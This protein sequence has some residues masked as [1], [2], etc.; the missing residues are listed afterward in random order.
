V[1]V[2]YGGGLRSL[3]DIGAALDAGAS[4]V[5]LGTALFDEDV[6]RGALAAFGDRVAAALDAR[7]GAAAVEGW[8]RTAPLSV[9]DAARRL[10][11]A[12]VARFVYTDVGRDGM[13][14]GPNLE[15]LRRLRD[16]VAVPVILSGGIGTP[17]DV[18]AAA[19]AGAEGAIVGR[20][21]YEGRIT[22]A[23]ALAA[24]GERG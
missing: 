20:A 24:A 1:S 12:G 5:I 15:G 19:A 13:L 11:A 18:R 9:L 21:L 10:A 8:R 23:Q 3:A 7:D 2:Q 6:L 17:E 16:E 4:R 22:L 14:V